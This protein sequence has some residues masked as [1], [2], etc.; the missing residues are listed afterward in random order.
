MVLAGIAFVWLNSLVAHAVHFYGDVRYLPE[1]LF[2]S[3]VFQASISIVWTLTAFSIMG[4]ATR[5]GHRKFWFIGGSLLAAVVLKLFIIDLADIGT[6]ARIVSFMTVGI[7]MLVIG[8]ISPLP[9]KS[10]EESK[11]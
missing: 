5:I 9:P 11:L 7:L 1:P 8:Y 6:I 3:A 10:S 2:H 4:L